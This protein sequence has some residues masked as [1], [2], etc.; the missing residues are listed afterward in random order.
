M[1]PARR[2][3]WDV[4]GLLRSKPPRKPF[5]VYVSNGQ[6]G[7]GSHAAL[8]HHAAHAWAFAEVATLQADW[9]QYHIQARITSLVPIFCPQGQCLATCRKA[10]LLPKGSA[11]C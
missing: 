1:A 5:H 8:L 11:G 4:R 6:N 9:L 3:L 2:Q 10:Q 7:T